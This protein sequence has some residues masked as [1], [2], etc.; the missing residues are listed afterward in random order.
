MGDIALDTLHG[1][2]IQTSPVTQVDANGQPHIYPRQVNQIDCANIDDVRKVL[3][4]REEGLL[5]DISPLPGGGPTSVKFVLYTPKALMSRYAFTPNYPAKD[6]VMA[7]MDTQGR[8][9]E[10]LFADAM[11]KSAMFGTVS[12]VDSDNPAEEPLDGADYKVWLDN[13]LDGKPVMAWIVADAK[14]HKR[15]V[16]MTTGYAQTFG[17]LPD[18]IAR[19]KTAMDGLT[20]S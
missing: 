17:G 8:F 20:G 4:G 12:V 7:L 18:M 14:G 10:K 2:A 6:E 3:E 9:A 1:Y 5:A 11:R 16:Q 15:A 13:K 19:M